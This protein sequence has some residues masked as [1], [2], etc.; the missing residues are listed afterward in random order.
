MLQEAFDKLKKDLGS[1]FTFIQDGGDYDNF[2][3]V[4]SAFLDESN[5][6]IEFYIIQSHYNLVIC[7]GNYISYKQE[8]LGIMEE[9][10]VRWIETHMNPDMVKYRN[11]QYHRGYKEIRFTTSMETL[12]K[13]VF[14]FAFALWQIQNKMKNMTTS[15][16]TK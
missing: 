8:N 3:K 13:D 11:L 7:D 14:E 9:D 5:D 12:T 6:Y 15:G 10:P 4:T 16:E 1:L 2:I